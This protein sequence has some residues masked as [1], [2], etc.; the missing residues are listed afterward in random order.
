MS[1]DTK[2]DSIIIECER[3]SFLKSFEVSE[4]RKSD[5]SE[6]CRL[7]FASWPLPAEAHAPARQCRLAAVAHTREHARAQVI[8]R[9]LANHSS[10]PKL[11]T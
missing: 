9:Q 4:L 2:I 7:L 10:P 6:F 5:I 1:K 3:H 11:H 8:L